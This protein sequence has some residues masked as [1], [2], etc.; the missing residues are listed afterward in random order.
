M[1]RIVTR[2]RNAENLRNLTIR[3]AQVLIPKAISFV[4]LKKV[5]PFVVND[6]ERA[7]AA[8]FIF[9]LL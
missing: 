8:L 3:Q 2:L 1:L 4:G 7:S 6:D 5:M 9:P